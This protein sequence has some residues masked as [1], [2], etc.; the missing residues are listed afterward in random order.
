MIWRGR[1]EEA[2]KR[3]SSREEN[4]HLMAFDVEAHHV[5]APQAEEADQRA[6]RYE[7]PALRPAVFAAEA[8]PMEARSRGHRGRHPRTR[9]GAIEDLNSAAC[10]PDDLALEAELVVRAHRR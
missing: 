9:D 2:P 1:T 7:L 6:P 3:S 4:G 8:Q 10:A 5:D